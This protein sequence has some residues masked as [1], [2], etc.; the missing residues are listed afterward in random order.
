M[1][2][3]FADESCPFCLQLSPEIFDH[4]HF[5]HPRIQR[6]NRRFYPMATH[7]A[8]APAVLPPPPSF[9][10]EQVAEIPVDQIDRS[11]T[12]PRQSFN[13]RS[14]EELKASIMANGLV[15]PV[16]VRPHPDDSTR[17]QLVAGERRWL[18]SKR[19]ARDTI[20]AIVRELT[21][22]QALIVQIIEN[23]QRT[24][25]NPLE[26]G[27]G[28]RSLMQ[29]KPTYY[30]V[31]EIAARTGLSHRDVLYRLR[32]LEL[33]EPA[34]QLLAAERLPFRHAVEIARLQPAQQQEALSVCFRGVTADTVLESQYHTVSINLADLRAWITRNCFLD[35]SHAPFDIFAHDLAPGVGPCTTCPKRSGA[36]PVLFSEI[37]P[38]SETCSDPA[39]FK[40]KASALVEIQV[41]SLAQQGQTAV[42]ISDS[43]RVGAPEEK[44]DVLYRGQYRAVERDSCEFVQPGVYSEHSPHSGKSIYVCLEAD[45]PVHSGA[46][47]YTSPEDA[48]KQKE[49]PPDQKAEKQF[50]TVLLEEVRKKLGKVAR[51][52]DINLI[53]RTFFAHMAHQDRVA[54]FKLY[55]WD[56][57]KSPGKHGA[58]HVDYLQLAGRHLASM[59]S[60]EL[61]QFL[62]L[63]SLI[64]DLA[65]PASNPDESLSAK[66]AL[67]ETA[68]RHGIDLKDV[69][70]RI[71]Q[72]TGKPKR[73]PK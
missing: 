12:N 15:H 35:L 65:I 39:C 4:R 29:L 71:G 14:L 59:G 72:Q 43:F 28:F 26:Q 48:R 18:A 38:N 30:T 46:S 1:T 70:K 8:P 3:F 32:V 9:I 11:P 67:A 31:E 23:D 60:A 53:A 6:K 42:R 68:K 69:R 10:A 49:R 13:E 62:I 47:R 25:L 51:K 22:E 27:S 58:K 66:S 33:I 41:A 64:P 20:P 55:K 19:G 40:S 52:D 24:N 63:G 5:A 36:N 61:M 16:V 54:L 2:T 44:E 17:F 34:R 21:D 7:L 56:A 73:R 45:C 37:T 57:I 50:R